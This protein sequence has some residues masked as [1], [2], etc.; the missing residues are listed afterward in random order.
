M[1]KYCLLTRMVR[2][3]RYAVLCTALSLLPLAALA[4][5]VPLRFAWLSDT[6]VGSD[7]GEQDLNAAVN[8]IN[9][10]TGLSFVVISGDVTEYGSREQFKRAKQ[11]LDKLKLPYHSKVVWASGSGQQFGLGSFI[12]ANGLILSMND[13]GLLRLIE[14]LPQKYTLLAQA[15]VLK[16]RESWAPL[17]LAGGRLIVRDLTRMVC[18]EVGR[19]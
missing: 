16:G 7:T 3:L 13:S 14:A 5:S 1:Q 10:L 19:P 11:S 6:H 18:L 2:L 8:D 15:Q 4:A 17:A 9:S 12:L